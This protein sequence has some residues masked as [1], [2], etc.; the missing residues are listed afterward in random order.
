M[1][2]S[3]LC[4][5]C[6]SQANA[7]L[8]VCG[9]QIGANGARYGADRRVAVNPSLGARMLHPCSIRPANL[10]PYRAPL[11]LIA[12]LRGYSGQIGASGALLG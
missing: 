5:W 11:R 4:Q 6:L 1:W 2:L 7:S 3:D 9:G 10:S 8:R 12:S